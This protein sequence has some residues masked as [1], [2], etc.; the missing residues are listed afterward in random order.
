MAR[1]AVLALLALA[2]VLARAADVSKVHVLFMNHLDVGFASGASNG[3]VPGLAS[4]VVDIYFNKCVR[5]AE[6]AGMGRAR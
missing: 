1:L 2:L 6:G 5:G 4:T 3:G